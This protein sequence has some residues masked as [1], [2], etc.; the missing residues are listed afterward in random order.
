[1]NNTTRTDLADI[2]AAMESLAEQIDNLP[3]KAK[4]DVA[5]RLR[6]V[7]KAVKKIDEAVKD[8]IKK[9]L[10]HKAGVLTGE[11]F[12]AVLSLIP[13]ERLNQQKLQVEQPRVY[14]KY[15]ET[16]DQERVTFEVR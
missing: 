1:M 12:K 11:L 16:N 14:A 8:E 5:A 7:E 9:S 2:V 10:K 15:L 6:P 13:T 3:L 4:I